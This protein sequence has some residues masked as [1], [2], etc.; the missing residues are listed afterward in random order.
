MQA[1]QASLEPAFQSITAG[2]ARDFAYVDGVGVRG[3]VLL[4]STGAVEL[5]PST[6]SGTVR[7][8]PAAGCAGEHA[9]CS[10]EDGS[11]RHSSGG[12]PVE[13]RLLTVVLLTNGWSP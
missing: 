9:C 7:R 12:E 1:Q 11:L 8:A 10:A 13:V 3:V 2:L 5:T 4:A 6:S